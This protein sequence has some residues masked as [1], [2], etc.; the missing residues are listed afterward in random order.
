MA[1]HFHCSGQRHDRAGTRFP[2]LQPSLTKMARMIS[3]PRNSVASARSQRHGRTDQKWSIP[4]IRM[5]QERAGRQSSA[6]FDAQNAPYLS[7]VNL[8]TS[9]LSDGIYTVR[10]EKTESYTYDGVLADPKITRTEY[11]NFDGYGNAG[12]EID[13]GD[14]AVTGDETYTSRELCIIRTSGSSTR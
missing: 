8:W 9:S 6:I 1:C 14:I 5:T 12:L 13:H 4:S 7:A 11:K 10:L 2:P 3:P